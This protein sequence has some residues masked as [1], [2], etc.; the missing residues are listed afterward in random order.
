MPKGLIF[1]LHTQVQLYP[2][3][4]HQRE[5]AQCSPETLL[6]CSC[7][8]AT[9]A[10]C[11][12]IALT[13]VHIA[14]RLLPVDRPLV[15]FSLPVSSR[16]MGGQ[17]SSDLSERESEPEY[18]EARW[19]ISHPSHHPDRVARHQPRRILTVAPS[20]IGEGGPI[21][22]ALDV[23]ASLVGCADAFFVHG[24]QELSHRT[25]IASNLAKGESN[26]ALGH[27]TFLS[28]MCTLWLPFYRQATFK[29]GNWDVAYGDIRK[30]FLSFLE[31][32]APGR[33]IVL[34]GHSQGGVM[35]N[36]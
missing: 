13:T 3:N 31:G 36:K 15:Y 21:D 12:L 22:E 34:A 16:V 26:H 20:G 4:R 24:T 7:R 30:A 11:G 25:N 19:W 2:G 23:D 28:P 17:N 9:L 14:F 8:G 29:G 6:S 33:P 18:S 27:A 10:V 5:Q 35:V 32:T 1:T